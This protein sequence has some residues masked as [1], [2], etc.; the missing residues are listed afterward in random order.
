M[1]DFF[2]YIGVAVLLV[3]SFVLSLIVGVAFLVFLVAYIFA[4]LLVA[5][6]IWAA[7]DL[8]QRYRRWKY[9][10]PGTIK[11]KGK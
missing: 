3:V 2:K 11:Q 1:N 9:R 7:G 6:I 10:K 5:A 4:S 8:Q